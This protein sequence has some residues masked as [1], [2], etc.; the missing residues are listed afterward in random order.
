MFSDWLEAY[1]YST[2]IE[3]IERVFGPSSGIKHVLF[4]FDTTLH[5]SS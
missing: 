1:Q 4:L 5:F 3:C 2:F